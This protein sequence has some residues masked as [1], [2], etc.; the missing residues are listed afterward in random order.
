LKRLRRGFSRADW[1]GDGIVTLVLGIAVAVAVFLP[2]A[3]VSTGHN[4]N[5]SPSAATGINGALA[6][7]WGLPVLALA[8]V[9]VVVGVVMIA[10]RPVKLSIL[11]CVAVSA[12]GLGITLVCFSAGWHIWDPLRPGLGL[13]AATLA[14]ILLIPTGLAS[15]MVAYI[16]NS[17]A[18]MARVQARAA[19][20]HGAAS[21]G[22]TTP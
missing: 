9:I 18:I 6:T 7:P 1:V 11:L 4:V 3:N 13:F 5:L 8:A 15:A 12:A 21:A 16:L 10:T 17:P 14:G 22:E 2:W 19:A 20:R